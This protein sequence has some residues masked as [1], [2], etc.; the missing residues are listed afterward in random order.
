MSW[1]NDVSH[2]IDE[3]RRILGSGDLLMIDTETSGGDVPVVIQ[4]AAINVFGHSM[5]DVNIKPLHPITP[6]A[7]FIHGITDEISG[8]FVEYSQVHDSIRALLDSH[9]V[10]AY[11]VRY[12][13]EVLN[14]TASAAGERFVPVQTFCVMSA[15][16]VINGEESR[17]G[18]YKWRSLTYA[19]DFF[20][21]DYSLLKPHNAL[22]DS[23]AALSVLKHIALL[24]PVTHVK[25]RRV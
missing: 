14:N 2:T 4:F 19:L 3:A 6:D 7:V 9:C 18:G 23:L 24:D 10:C 11:N 8:A 17:H 1:L 22:D 15:F 16:A 12:D 20:G 21:I 5:M 25:A 13:I